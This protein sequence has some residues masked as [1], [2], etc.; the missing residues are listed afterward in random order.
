MTKI[1]SWIVPG[2]LGIAM[3]YALLA[4]APVPAKAGTC[5]PTECS[6]FKASLDEIC[7]SREC[8]GGGEVISCDTVILYEC[9]GE[10]TFCNQA[11]IFG[12]CP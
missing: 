3:M 12:P 5:T 1:R 8:T 9:F 2:L 7:D 6:E 4:L 10:G 11:Q